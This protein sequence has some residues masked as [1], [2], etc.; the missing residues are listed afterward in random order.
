MEA[1]ASLSCWGVDAA[2]VEDRLEVEASGVGS[3]LDLRSALSRPA[4]DFR[5]PLTGPYCS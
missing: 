1:V 2:E 4:P 3:V 5:I